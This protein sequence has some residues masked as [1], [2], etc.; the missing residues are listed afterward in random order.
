LW[1]TGGGVGVDNIRGQIKLAAT[2]PEMLENGDES[3]R[4][5]ARCSGWFIAA[6]TAAGVNNQFCEHIEPDYWSPLFLID[7]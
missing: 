3:P 5:S 2:L 1:D 7:H 6:G 4:Y